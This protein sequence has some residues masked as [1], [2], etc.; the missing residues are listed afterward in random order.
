MP[1]S[2]LRFMRRLRPLAAAIPLLLATVVL[3][4]CGSDTKPQASAPTDGPATIVP[5]SAIVYGEVLVRP[6]GDVEQGVVTAARRMLRVVDPGRALRRLFDAESDGQRGTFTSEIDPWLGDTV[7]G[8]LLIE[9]AAGAESPDGAVIAAVRD[10]AAAEQAIDRLRDEGDLSRGGT[11]E[12]VTYDVDRR[13]DSWTGIVGDFVVVGTAEGFRAAVVA[14]KGRSL[15]EEDRFTRNVDALADDRLA[16]A[17]VEPR[18]ITQ[19]LSEQSQLD[20]EFERAL[21]GQQQQ[22]ERALGSVPITA[23]LTARADEVVFD[24]SSSSAELPQPGGDGA[25]SLG[26]LPGDAWAALATPVLGELIGRSLR[27]SGQYDEAARAVRGAA[28]LDLDRDLLG[29]LGGVAAFVRGSSPLDLGGGIVIGS[30]DPAASQ[31]FVARLERFAGNAGLPTTPTTG[32]GRGFQ[33]KIPQLPQPL[34]VLAQDDKV[35][36]GLGMASA[37]DALKPD[38][39]LADTEPGKSAIAALGDGFE[40]S[41]VLV[42]E[43]LIILLR[44]VGLDNDPDFRSALP[45]L[46]AYRSIV[47]GSKNEDGRT[48]GRLTLSL[49]DPDDTADSGDGTETATRRRRRLA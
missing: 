23:S 39:A 18:G 27:Q 7:G 21:D 17:Y 30:G 41:F 20:P 48:T 32:A 10:R 14:S 25:V 44:A 36:L 38:E 47:A 31:R 1:S 8:F 9:T 46:T 11:Y 42:P 13:D 5:P 16:W 22:L 33:L 4:A 2:H 15:A 12:G 26:E 35:V 19:L 6:S 29:W 45:Y 24:V 3:A 37:R 40:P 43:P 34:V 49:Q 28:A